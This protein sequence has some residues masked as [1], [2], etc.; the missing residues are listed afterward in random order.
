MKW[1][2]V[3]SRSVLTVICVAMAAGPW[4]RNKSPSQ[5]PSRWFPRHVPRAASVTSLVDTGTGQWLPAPAPAPGP[6]HNVAWILKCPVSAGFLASKWTTETW[7]LWYCQM[8][9]EWAWVTW[10]SAPASWTSGTCPRTSRPSAPWTRTGTEPPGSRSCPRTRRPSTTMTTSPPL[11]GHQHAQDPLTRDTWALDRQSQGE[12]HFWFVFID[13]Y[14]F[15]IFPDLSR[16]QMSS[17]WRMWSSAR[18]RLWSTLSLS[19]AFPPCRPDTDFHRK[20]L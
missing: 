8:P 11:A 3:K 15:S 20:L 18:P 17:R 9:R 6:H 5:P 16:A 19:P 13:F 10:I 12:W 2:I 14:M 1:V 4:S 7:S